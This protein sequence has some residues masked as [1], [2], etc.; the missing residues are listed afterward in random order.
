[1]NHS[2]ASFG[3]YAPTKKSAQTLRFLTKIGLGRGALTKRYSALW[4]KWHGDLVDT[5]VR[6]LRYR[7][8]LSNNITDNRILCSSK[9]YDAEELQ[10]LKNACSHGGVFIDVGANIGYYSLRMAKEGATKVISIEP[11]PRA[12]ERLRFNLQANDF[13][14]IITTIN[15][16]VGDE[17][18]HDLFF[19][20]DLGSASLI[21]RESGTAENIRIETHPLC[22]ILQSNGVEKIDGMKVD[23]EGLESLILRKFY[24]EAP[25]SLWPKCLVIEYCHHESWSSDLLDHLKSLGYKIQTRTRANVILIRP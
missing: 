22:K 6:G 9:E 15:C 20:G 8:N 23:V 12:M 21:E 18:T 14:N 16:G 2:E 10:A 3:T 17:G 4:R 5:E 25:A 19:Y 24:E 7:L 13:D 11:N 1:M